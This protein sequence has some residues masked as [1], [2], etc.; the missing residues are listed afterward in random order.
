M[1]TVHKFPLKFAGHQTIEMPVGAKTLHLEVQHDQLCLWALVNTD[2][3]IETRTLNMY[4][5]GHP[6][7]TAKSITHIG[8]FLEAN[9]NLVWHV[10]MTDK[11]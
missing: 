6:V 1:H 11:S 8:T 2:A 7:D 3:K 4:G 10:F 5:T 9:G